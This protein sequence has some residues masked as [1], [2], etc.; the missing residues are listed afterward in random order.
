MFL[1]DILDNLPRLRISSSLM[2]VF[3]WILKEAGCKSVASFDHLRRVHKE[4]LGQCAIPSIPCKSTQGNVFFMNDP[5]AIIVQDWANPTTRRLIQLYPEI[6]QDGVIREIWHAQKWR[7][8][9]D[10]DIL[11]PMDAAG[12]THY[13]VNEV[14]CLLDDT[15]VIPIRWVIFRGKVW[16]DAFSVTF[17]EQVRSF[18]H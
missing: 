15:F 17:D 2:R 10:L 5:R 3:L 18:L 14:A 8:N 9:M 13:Y 11:S 4:L 6:P 12:T 16:A 7:K 1:L